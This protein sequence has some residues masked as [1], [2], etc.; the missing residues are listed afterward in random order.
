MRCELL[1]SVVTVPIEVRP[2]RT[3]TIV[4]AQW[5]SRVPHYGRL[6]AANLYPGIDP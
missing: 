6:W 1:P 5:Q 2:S 3:R 4:S